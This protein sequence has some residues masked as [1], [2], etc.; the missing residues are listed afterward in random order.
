MLIKSPV[1]NKII[2]FEG[3]MKTDFSIYPF[4]SQLIVAQLD[5]YS[6]FFHAYV[7]N[8]YT[9]VFPTAWKIFRIFPK[10]KSFCFIARPWFFF[11][12]CG[13]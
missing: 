9:F 7:N 2:N 13:K 8:K 3:F 6:V 4:D 10:K 11:A 1:K 12:N 5:D